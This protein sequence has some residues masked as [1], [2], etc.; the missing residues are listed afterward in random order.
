MFVPCYEVS[1]K[2]VSLLG[3]TQ[4][5]S[6]H[7]DGSLGVPD[8]DAEDDL[9]FTV[10]DIDVP[11]VCLKGIRDNM[12]NVQDMEYASDMSPPDTSSI[13]VQ[14]PDDLFL[15]IRHNDDFHSRVCELRYH[16]G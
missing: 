12:T 7:Y 5:R 10:S 6:V 16:G 15:L 1:T 11:E 4:P 13:Q 9:D 2:C 8:N 3:P 14:V